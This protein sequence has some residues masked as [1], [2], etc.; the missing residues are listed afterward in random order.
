M[1]ACPLIILLG[2]LMCVPSFANQYDDDEKIRLWAEDQQKQ[3]QEQRDAAKQR[4]DDAERKNEDNSG[5][6]FVCLIVVVG[7]AAGI[8]HHYKG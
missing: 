6:G 8:W 1:K 5:G 3:E 4:A 7:I 2:F